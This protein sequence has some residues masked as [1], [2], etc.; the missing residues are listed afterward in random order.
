MFLFFGTQWAVAGM[1]CLRLGE[2][3]PGPPGAPAAFPSG[4]GKEG[5]GGQEPEQS[6]CGEGA[7]TCLDVSDLGGGRQPRCPW[8]SRGEREAKKQG[9][10]SE[11]TPTKT[12]IKN[13]LTCRRKR[14]EKEEDGVWSWNRKA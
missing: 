10:P 5:E 4:L 2:E 12:T 7:V 14:A 11:A 9:R 13:T 3:Q 6:G 8:R 1:L